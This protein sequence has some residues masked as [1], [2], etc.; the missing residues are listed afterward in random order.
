MQCVCGGGLEGSGTVVECM[1]EHR[2]HSNDVG[3][4][5]AAFDRIAQEVLAEPEALF[6]LID[7]QP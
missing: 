4:L 6:L 3:R 2:P 5:D 1:D 7:C